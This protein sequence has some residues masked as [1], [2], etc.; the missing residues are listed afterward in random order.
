MSVPGLNLI[1][2]SPAPV[3]L[4]SIRV[5]SRIARRSISVRSPSNAGNA[6][7][8]TVGVIKVPSTD[9]L[10]LVFKAIGMLQSYVHAWDSFPTP[11]TYKGLSLNVW[12]ELRPRALARMAVL[13]A[14]GA[15]LRFPHEPGSIRSPCLP[16]ASSVLLMYDCCSL[17]IVG[18]GIVE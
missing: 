2:E 4:I 1:S 6:L 13:R 12:T 10:S 15:P 14:H 17:G 9:R 18:F 7:S 16:S 8:S 5:K 11:E 3:K